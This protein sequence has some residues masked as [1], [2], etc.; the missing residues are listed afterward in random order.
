MSDLKHLVQQ[1]RRRAILKLLAD[2]VSYRAGSPML[3]LALAGDGHS[4]GLDAITADLVWLHEVGLLATLIPTG[5]YH[6][7]TLSTRGLDVAYGRTR[8][9]G[10]ARPLPE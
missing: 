1:D 10:V 8:V 3:Q 5:E 2:A 7:A 4:I 6:V 9:P